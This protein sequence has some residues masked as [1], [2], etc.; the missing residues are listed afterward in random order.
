VK[1]PLTQAER[2]AENQRNWLIREEQKAR[3][4]RGDKGAMETWMRITRVVISREA[5]AGRSDV[6]AAYSLV[7]RLFMAAVRKRAAG[8]RRLWDDL[9]RYAQ[10]V[11]E[12]EPRH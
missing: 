3:E 12:R 2:A 4:T 1:R 5:R 11:V 9:L 10:Q 8:D 6:Y 7:N